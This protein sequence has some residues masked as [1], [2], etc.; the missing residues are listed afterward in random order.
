MTQE[1]AFAQAHLWFGNTK[2]KMTVPGVIVGNHPSYLH[3]MT[4]HVGVRQ[5]GD[6]V[7]VG[8]GES[9]EAAFTDLL[10]LCRMVVENQN[11]EKKA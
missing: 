1:E 11:Q 9:F 6:W 8:R 7:I 10:G 2:D 5:R 3:G 4:Y